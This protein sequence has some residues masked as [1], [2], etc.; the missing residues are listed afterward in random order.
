ME[1]KTTLSEKVLEDILEAI[2]DQVEL[3]FKGGK[4]EG[5]KEVVD[6]I[7]L[8]FLEGEDHD[9]CNFK[10]SLWQDKLKEWG[11]NAS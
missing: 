6:F 4:Q 10:L 9:F 2:K 1:A 7:D 11:I 3:S 5:R 8:Y